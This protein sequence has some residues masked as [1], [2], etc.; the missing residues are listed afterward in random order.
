M[1]ASA[2][3]LYRVLEHL[4]ALLKLVTDRTFTCDHVQTGQRSVC[5]QLSSPAFLSPA[6]LRL[7]RCSRHWLRRHADSSDAPRDDSNQPRYNPRRLY[8]HRD[9]YQRRCHAVYRCYRC[10]EL[11]A[12]LEASIP[13]QLFPRYRAASFRPRLVRNFFASRSLSL[14]FRQ[15][16]AF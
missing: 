15:M 9:R 8:H 2:A 4:P 3:I 12:N 7:A 6:F 10:S 16:G 1:A 14:R 11:S 13:D 5:H